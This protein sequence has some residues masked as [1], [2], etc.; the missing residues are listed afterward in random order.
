MR[1][2][3]K[4]DQDGNSENL[5]LRFRPQIRNLHTKISLLSKFRRFQKVLLCLPEEGQKG[6]I[7]FQIFSPFFDRCLTLTLQVRIELKFKKSL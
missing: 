2:S 7:F 3:V 1:F 4:T 6:E 5:I